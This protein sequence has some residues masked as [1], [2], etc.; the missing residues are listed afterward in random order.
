MNLTLL[1]PFKVSEV[2]E[3]IEDYFLDSIGSKAN[4]ATF[5]RRGNYLAVGNQ[6]GSV[7]IWDF[8]AKTIVRILVGHKQCINSVCWSRNGKKILSCSNDGFIFYWD[9][10]T[11]TIE[12]QMDLGSPVN[13]AQIH[14]RDPKT[15][16]ISAQGKDPILL[17]F[18]TMT[19]KSFLDQNNNNLNSSGAT[20]NINNNVVVSYSHKGEKIFV[21]DSQGLIT[22]LDSKSFVIEKTIK[23][24]S[25]SIIKEFQFS[26][27]GKLLLVNSADKIIRLYSL[28]TF[29]PLQD[30][31]DNVNKI[32][33][34]KCCFSNNSE[35]VI[36]GMQ[37]KTVQ[38]IVVWSVV[39]GI[40]KDL[41][42]PKEGLLDVV[43]HPLRPIII[44]ISQFGVIY[45]WTTYY[46][47]N[48]SSFA[49][50]FQELEENEEYIEREDEFDV[51]DDELDEEANKQQQL[52]EMEEMDEEIDITTNDKIAEFSSDE[53]EEIFCFS[54]VPDPGN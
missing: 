50:D 14:P 15:C 29:L 43:W 5:N 21:G 11:A 52:N 8:D 19:T 10:E 35:Y 49:P 23:L 25:N 20:T 17:D 44:S 2:P 1:D 12:R 22:I 7:S 38:N 54:I 51:K 36:G 42:G 32:Q 26:K 41:E 46:T 47:E 30:Y 16:L 3:A 39:G 45:I 31:Q 24:P 37:H 28:E 53:E 48:W 18:E 13:F 6:G 4:C 40:V 34:K 33:W 9:I 27:N